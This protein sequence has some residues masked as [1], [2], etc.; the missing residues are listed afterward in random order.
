MGPT[1]HL[2]IIATLSLALL[3]PFVPL[4]AQ[5]YGC[6]QGYLAYFVQ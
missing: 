3:L 4:H 5:T 2:V 6:Y 1:R